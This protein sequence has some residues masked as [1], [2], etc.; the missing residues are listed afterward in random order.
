MAGS[1]VLEPPLKKMAQLSQLSEALKRNTSGA[2]DHGRRTPEPHAAT[3]DEGQ[4]R[5]WTNEMCTKS[6]QLFDFVITVSVSSS[7]CL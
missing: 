4:L 7:E 1:S 2:S 6:P 3:H 5:Y